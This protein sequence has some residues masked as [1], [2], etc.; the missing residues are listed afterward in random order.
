ML[1]DLRGKRRRAVQFT[2]AGLA[3]LMAVGLLGAGVGSGVSGGIFDIFTGGGNG[4]SLSDANKP[5]KKKIDQANSKLKANPRDQAAL[6][7]LV[8]GHYTL[9]T[10]DT[11]PNDGSFGKKGKGEL[12]KAGTAW[13]AYL[14]T[15]P[16][17]VDP[18]L[19]T[20]MTTAYGSL[21]L[22]Q[23][24]NAS[25]AAEI[26][27]EQRN[28]ASSYIQLVQYATLAGQKRKADLAAAKALELAPKDQRDTVKTLLKQAQA[29]QPP[30]SQGGTGQAP[31]PGG[32]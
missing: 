26:V 7:Q 9:A 20:L 4:T 1:F 27:A 16:E 2:Y 22:N 31:V 15:K 5:V 18:A 10:S 24:A 21:G 19:A 30:A 23:A 28:D 29:T 3:L 6:I 12:A 17:K 13:K 32:G 25:E 14:A 11:D 8:R